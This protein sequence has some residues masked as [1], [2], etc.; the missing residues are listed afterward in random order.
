MFSKGFFLTSLKLKKG[1]GLIFKIFFKFFQ[2]LWKQGDLWL[3]ISCFMRY[4]NA[5]LTVDDTR[6]ICGQCRPEIRLHILCSLISDLHCPH[7]HSRLF[8]LSFSLSC[9]QKLQPIYSVVKEFIQPSR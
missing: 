6:S 2:G 8:L 3:S 5:F 4:R 9:N 7:F 1:K